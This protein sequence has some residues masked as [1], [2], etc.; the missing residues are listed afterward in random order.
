MYEK[1]KKKLLKLKKELD[2]RLK[3]V[4]LSLMKKRSSDWE[5]AAVEAENDEVLEG[6]FKEALKNRKNSGFQRFTRSKKIVA[7][8][9]I[10]P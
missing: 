1:Q 2:K 10:L 3:D 5:E 6:V 4:K 7:K 9:V 8:I